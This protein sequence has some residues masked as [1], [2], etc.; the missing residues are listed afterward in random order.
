[1]TTKKDKKKIVWQHPGGKFRR[2]GPA[3]CSETEL[4][5]IVLGSGGAGR[6]ATE[7]AR[8]ILDRYGH[9]G[10]LAGKSLRELMEI[11]GLKAVKVTRLAAVFEISRR[12]LKHIEREDY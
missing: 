6:T 7:I 8:E 1:M 10:R 5:A 2:E 9:I 3:A 4:L 12:L 11:K